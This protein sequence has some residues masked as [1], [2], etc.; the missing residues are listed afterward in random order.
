MR[1][2]RLDPVDTQRSSLHWGASDAAPTRVWVSADNESDARGRVTLAT[3]IA[4]RS[5]PGRE[6]PLTPWKDWG[7]VTCV[8]DS[9]RTVPPNVIVTASGDTLEIPN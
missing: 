1:V 8:E 9:S 5:R 3:I 6:I 7:L 2:F 4:T